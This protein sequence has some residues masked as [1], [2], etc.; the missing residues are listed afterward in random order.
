MLNFNVHN[1]IV[2][3][4]G[5]AYFDRLSHGNSKMH[6]ARTYRRWTSAY[7]TLVPFNENCGE[8]VTCGITRLQKRSATRVSRSKR[9]LYASHET[10][11]G[12]VKGVESSGNPMLNN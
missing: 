7:I 9:K 12:Y 6:G 8:N 4:F 3:V 2:G 10:Y 5:K 11:R 1:Y